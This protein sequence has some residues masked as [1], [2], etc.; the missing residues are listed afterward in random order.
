MTT[1][2]R[3]ETPAALEPERPAAAPAPPRTVAATLVSAREA[4]Q[5]RQDD[6]GWWKGELETNVTMDAEDLM[7]RHIIGVFDP[8]QAARAAVWIRS[9][10]RPDGTW[11]NYFGSPADLSTT[12]EAYVALRLAGD[13]PQAPHLAAAAA[14]VREAGGLEGTRV[15]TRMWLAMVAEWS[16]DDLPALPPELIYLPRWFPLN[17]YDFACW[18]RQ[19]IVPLTIVGSL[20]PSH[21]LPFRLT[22]LRTGRRPTLRPRLRSAAGAFH[23]LDKALHTYGR[24]AIGPL[25]RAALARSATWIIQR[26]EADGGW[27]G[28]QPPWVYSLIALVELGYPVDHCVVRA[29]L[30]GLDGFTIDDEKGRRLEACQSPVWDTVLAMVA[31]GDAGVLPG[32]PAMLAAARWVVGEEIRVRGDWAVRRPSLP[33]GGWA[34]EFANDLY[35]DVDD[36]AEVVLGLRR[37]DLTQVAG[38]EDAVQRGIAWA[39]GMQSR[40]GGWGAFDADNTRSLAYEIPFADFGAMIDPPSADV[41]AHMVE[42]LAAEGRLGTPEVD[43]GVAWLLDAQEPDGSWFGRWGA[44]FVYGTAAV[45][46]ALTDAGVGTAH[47]AVRRA[48]RWLVAVANDDGGWGEDLRSYESEAAAE[49]WRARGPSTASQTAW[50]MIALLAGL[51]DGADPQHADA[52]RALHVGARWLVDTQRPDGTWDEPQF[53]GTGFPG[54]FYINYHLYRLVFPVTALGRYVSRFAGSSLGIPKLGDVPL[55]A[56]DPDGSTL[57][58]STLHRSR[59]APPAATGEAT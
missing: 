43:R 31:L 10:Q 50:A 13:E 40:D 57:H 56:A 59:P 28:I 39:T 33:T 47:P 15:F 6:A 20:R 35:P 37:A 34:F 14:Y 29:G 22:E 42:M 27:G 48:V 1:T 4:L 3:S 52:V 23:L 26:Q 9:Q 44:N 12:V 24:H 36:T 54:D 49:Q 2:E 32:D 38:A 5:A 58:G 7:L 21:P 8:E 45:V 53:N 46:P 51:P 25:R 41:T 19:T 17:V 18:A 11:G 16:W 30:A 55:G